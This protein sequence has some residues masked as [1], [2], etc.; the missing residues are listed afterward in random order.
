MDNEEQ[1]I[2]RICGNNDDNKRYNVKEMM[3]GLR[4]EF[5]YYECS[6]CKCL[7]IKSIPKEISKYYPAEYYSFNS[8]KRKIDNFIIK[9][10]KLVIGQFFIKTKVFGRDS[11]FLKKLGLSFLEVIKGV[12]IN[13]NSKILDVGSGDGEKLNILASAGFNNLTGIDPFI[14]QDVFYDNNVKIYKKEISEIKEKFDMVMLNHSFEHMDKPEQRLKEI[15]KLLK[16]SSTLIIRIPVAD[17][18]AW[19][20]YG[21]NWVNLDAPRHFYLYTYQSI[22]ILADKTDFEIQN[23]TYDSDECQFWVSEQY[24]KNIPMHDEH[25]YYKGNKSMFTKEQIKNY[26]TQ[27]K[28]LNR[29]GEGDKACFYL[30]K[31]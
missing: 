21:T 28:E 2:C 30:K 11:I 22:K 19:N 26:K 15:K 24:T 5:E 12:N 1:F 18:Y 20:N 29:S 3:F 13:F 23:V 7:Q 27:A 4:D 6:S 14:K 10:F 9:F 31:K 17:S 25:S 16:S 8:D